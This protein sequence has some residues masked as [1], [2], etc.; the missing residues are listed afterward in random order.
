MRR[1]DFY[2]SL[3]LAALV[4][5]DSQARGAAAQPE[6]ASGESAAAAEASAEIQ[7]VLA[8]GAPVGPCPASGDTLE[9]TDTASFRNEVLGGR[10]ATL[11]A[12]GTLVDTVDLAFGVHRVGRDSVVFLPVRSRPGDRPGTTVPD[13]TRHVLCAGALR[14]PLAPELP[15]F[16]DYFSSPV[17]IDSALVYW[18]LQV[19]GEG[20]YVLT[21]RRYHFPTA[22]H[23]SL[24]LTRAPLQTDYRFHLPQPESTA[25]GALFRYQD[26]A[27]TLPRRD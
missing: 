8:P 11:R 27:W 26:D 19:H 13:I 25:A 23:D 14:V 24:A 21:A 10:R 6:T 12:A 22:R 4:A 18:G 15:A 5:C 9:L 2:V 16:D 20:V 7:P 1:S 3:W 17:V